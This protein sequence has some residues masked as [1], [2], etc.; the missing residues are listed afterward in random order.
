[1]TITMDSL[2]ADQYTDIAVWLGLIN[3]DTLN[4]K[5]VKGRENKVEC[6]NVEQ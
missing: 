4:G 3:Y 6:L 1:M 5:K 2:T